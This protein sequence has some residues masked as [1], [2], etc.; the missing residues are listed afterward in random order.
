MSY[1]SVLPYDIVVLIV[2]II[3]EKK[4]IDLLK[5]LALVSHFLLLI[6]RKHLFATV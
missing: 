6:C 3:A 2:D 4:D 5:E 1:E